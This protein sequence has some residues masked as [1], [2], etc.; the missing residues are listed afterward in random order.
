MISFLLFRSCVHK[1][2]DIINNMLSWP[3]G[4]VLLSQLVRYLKARGNELE[5][6]FVLRKEGRRKLYSTL[7]LRRAGSARGSQS[8]C[9]DVIRDA[10]SWSAS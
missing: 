8:K 1:V 3:A 4:S 7:Y 2:S 10:H 5:S 6:L 9:S